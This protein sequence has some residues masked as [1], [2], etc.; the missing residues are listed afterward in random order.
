M[1]KKKNERTLGITNSVS[2]MGNAPWNEEERHGV[3]M[4]QPPMTPEQRQAARREIVRQGEQG[5]PASVAR[6]CSRV[7][8]HRTAVY[9]LLKR[10]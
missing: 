2:R 10:V 6:A 4:A 5:A 3:T 9:W 8:M 1:I 7:P